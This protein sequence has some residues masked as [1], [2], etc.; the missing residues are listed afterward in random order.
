MRCAK[1]FTDA[2]GQITLFYIVDDY[3]TFLVLLTIDKDGNAVREE[4]YLLTPAL[5]AKLQVIEDVVT[6]ERDCLRAALVAAACGF[7]TR[8]EADVGMT[9]M[10]AHQLHKRG[11]WADVKGGAN[12]TD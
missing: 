3:D 11:F 6:D 5:V 4:D 7:F 9:A 10:Q 8:D 1:A 2:K 12:E